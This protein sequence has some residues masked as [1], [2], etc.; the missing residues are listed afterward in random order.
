MG[1]L[2]VPAEGAVLKGPLTVGGWARIPGEDL[3]VTIL[4]DGEKRPFLRGARI[5]RRDVQEALPR[6][7]LEF[8]LVAR[9]D[10]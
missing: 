8:E 1:S 10:A 9:G 3:D 4:I 6:L 5:P 2:D 7:A